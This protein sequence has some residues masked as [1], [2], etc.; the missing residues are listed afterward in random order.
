MNN[1]AKPLVPEQRQISSLYSRSRSRPRTSIKGNSKPTI[2]MKSDTKSS[3]M[4]ITT[5]EA[6]TK[7]NTASNYKS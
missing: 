7:N 6:S 1:A 3:H 5:N 4:F 2:P